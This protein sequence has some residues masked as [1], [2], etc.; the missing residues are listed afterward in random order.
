MAHFATPIPPLRAGDRLTPAEFDRRWDAT[1]RLKV[2]ELLDGVV[3]LPE[4]GSLRHGVPAAHLVGIT[5]IYAGFTEGTEG[6]CHSSL[7]L[8]DRNE[9]QPDALVLIEESHGGQARL[10]DDFLVT[11][12]E[13]VGEVT[14][15][16]DSY[17]LGV[18]LP[19][20]RRFGV[21]ECLVWRVLDRAIDYFVLR[22]GQ[23]KRL[24]VSLRGCYESEVLPGL[25]L[26][27]HAFIAG[28]TAAALQVMERGLASPEHQQFVERLARQAAQR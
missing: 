15:N 25:W 23:Y 4:I 5:G 22:D 10:V 27:P 3:Y 14:E 24:A 7:L 11:A 26:D 19:I 1:P 8:D 9:A 21:R 17:D 6:A 13:W 2:A 16:R 20:Y 12:P 28:D 18:K